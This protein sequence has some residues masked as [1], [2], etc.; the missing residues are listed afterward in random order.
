VV[1]IEAC[2]GDS[3]RVQIAVTMVI[4]D[5]VCVLAAVLRC[6]VVGANGGGGL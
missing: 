5:A 1:T 4:G 6:A 2:W 3:T